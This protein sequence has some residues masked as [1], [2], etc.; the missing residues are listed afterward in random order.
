MMRIDTTTVTAVR[1]DSRTLRAVT[2]RPLAREY[3]SSCAT[4]KKRGRSTQVTPMTR[5]ARTAKSTRSPLLV[6]SRLPKRYAVRLAG[7]PVGERAMSTTPRA[8]P[9]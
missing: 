7:V 8:M 4:A 9:P 5:A 1:T 6:V 2:G 3:S